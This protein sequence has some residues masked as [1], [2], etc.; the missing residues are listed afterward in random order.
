MPHQVPDSLKLAGELQQL[1]LEFLNMTDPSNGAM[2]ISHTC[3]KTIYIQ[4]ERALSGKL[5]GQ[6]VLLNA[7]LTIVHHSKMSLICTL[8]QH[9]VSSIVMPEFVI[10]HQ[11]AD[12]ADSTLAWRSKDTGQN[13]VNRYRTYYSRGANSNESINRGIERV[14]P[15]SGKVPYI[16][17]T[18]RI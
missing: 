6:S 3:L 16:S 7:A 1:V 4:I 2:L 11:H 14:L 12:P 10:Y 8:C 17:T 15:N 13:G 9:A 5:S 18:I